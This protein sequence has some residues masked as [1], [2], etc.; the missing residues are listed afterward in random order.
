[1]SH[2]Y[3]IYQQTKKNSRY[4]SRIV[5]RIRNKKM[6]IMSSTYLAQNNSLWHSVIL[7]ENDE[8]ETKKS[9]KINKS[10]L[11]TLSCSVDDV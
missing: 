9:I 2:L 1:M 6:I 4:S 8:L 10:I 7:K 5:A 11:F 3:N